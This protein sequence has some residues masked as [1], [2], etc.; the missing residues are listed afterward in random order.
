MKYI[1]LSIFL[2][3]SL[4]GVAQDQTVPD[5]SIKELAN[6]LKPGNSKFMLR[7]YYHTGFDNI[8]TGDEEVS[9]F[10]PG[11]IAPIL[12]YKQSDRLFFEAEFEGGFE[13]GKF[14]LGLEYA[15]VS[16]VL[17]D[18]MI[19]RAGKFLLPFGTFMEKLHPAWMNRL[20]TVPLGYGHDGIL[21]TSDIGVELRGAFYTGNIKLNYQVYAING[22]QL[23]VGGDEPEEDGMLDFGSFEDNN[24]DKTFGGRL[25]VFPFSNSSL[26][27]G[28]SVLNGA[29]GNQESDY[30]DVRTSMYAVD[31][32]FVRNVNF[33]KSMIDIKGQYNLVQ[34]DDANYDDPEGV[35][36]DQYTYDNESSAYY[37]Q[38]SIRPSMSGN[39]FLRKLELVGR[40]SALESPEG[41]LWEQNPTQTA[42]GLN[43]W[44][45]WRTVIK[46]GYQTTDGLGEHDA[47]ETVTSELFYV[48]WAIGF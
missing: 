34:T 33:L 39:D 9:R 20:S 8:N 7:G 41:A 17:N 37:G 35:L 22:P 44:I 27:L 26:E 40:Y 25:G 11:K 6:Y 18:Y 12:M 14:E 28:F 10:N 32:S 15:T 16:Y 21:P 3:S 47:D 19:A 5:N 36:G 31:L 23:K 24:L 13:D 38:L 46:I 45:D 43:Y 1:L 2:I 4:L 30:E 29:V 42:V 48:H